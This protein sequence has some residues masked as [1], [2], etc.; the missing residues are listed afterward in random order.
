MFDIEIIHIT[1]VTN[2][3]AD[4]LSRL[5]CHAIAVNDDW[6]L[7]YIADPKLCPQLFDEA[8]VPRDPEHYHHG[9]VW[10]FDQI[11]V[12]RRRVRQVIS[13]THLNVAFCHW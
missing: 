4:A 8:G 3:A 1:G 2:T 7:D 12:P 6:K 9:R 5:A 11:V 13:E 10:Y